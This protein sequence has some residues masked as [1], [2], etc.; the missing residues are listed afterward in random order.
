MPLGGCA[1]CG[2]VM[3]VVGIVGMVGARVR[4]CEVVEVWWGG[5]GVGVVGVGV[6]V[7]AEGWWSTG[8]EVGVGGGGAPGDCSALCCLMAGHCLSVVRSRLLL[9]TLHER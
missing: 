6:A 9:A 8:C 5:G 4:D 7:R 3:G 2:G 1:V